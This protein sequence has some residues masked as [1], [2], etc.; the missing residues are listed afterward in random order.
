MASWIVRIVRH[1][2]GV[3]SASSPS[4]KNPSAFAA[5]LMF[6]RLK[7]ISKVAGVEQKWLALLVSLMARV[8]IEETSEKVGK[9][10]GL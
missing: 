9:V 3:C 1:F 10:C 4:S 8:F 7:G 6:F 2:S 5:V